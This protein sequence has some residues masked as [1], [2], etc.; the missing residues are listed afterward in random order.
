MA[1]P[2]LTAE[3]QEQVQ[4]AIVVDH[5]VQAARRSPLALWVLCFRAEKGEPLIIKD[6]HEAAEIAALEVLANPE[7]DG[8]LWEGARGLTKTSFLIALLLWVVGHDPESRHKWL[9]AGDDSA[10]KRMT[11]IRQVLRGPTDPDELDYYHMVFP[12]VK[13]D[14]NPQAKNTETQLTLERHTMTP[15]PTLEC[16]GVLTSGVGGRCDFMWL[17]DI[18]DKR[19]ALRLQALRPQVISGMVNDWLPTLTPSG[20]VFSV[21]NVWHRE[22]ACQYMKDNMKGWKV[23]RTFHGEPGDLYHSIFP[24]LQPSDW[25]KRKHRQEKDTAYLRGRCGLLD[26]SGT[27]IVPASDLESYTAAAPHGLTPARLK[28]CEAV[29]VVDPASGKKLEKDAKLD[30][31]GFAVLLWMLNWVPRD[32]ESGD[33]DDVM[34]GSP[35]YYVWIPEAFQVKLRA[36]AAIKLTTAMYREWG[37][38]WLVIEDQTGL[39]VM[40]WFDDQPIPADAIIPAMVK[41]M[42]KTDRLTDAS[43]MLQ[44]AAGEPRIVRF[45]PRTIERHP[46]PFALALPDGTYVEAERTLRT[47][48]L[49]HPTPH[50]DVMDPV[51]HGIRFI[52]YQ[53]QQQLPDAHTGDMPQPLTVS[54]IG[55]G[56]IR[57]GGGKSQ[58]TVSPV[59]TGLMA[60][61]ERYRAENPRP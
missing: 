11:T 14:M 53:V 33:P 49:N 25:L 55:G 21:F 44:S 30:Y 36:N 15:E 58:G 22:D 46:Q 50:D 61:I 43:R 24:E 39:S 56:S 12:D 16:R 51:V 40:P 28:Y 17:D 23:M 45:H 47:Q 59:S 10:K 42:S 48:I 27:V 57:S 26:T 37:A 52:D 60:A 41:S 7:D 38:D 20:K 3:Q 32:P 35:P 31:W 34:L 1:Q 18:V 5:W 4:L 54:R 13:I 19:N 29:L 6:F 8:F 2:E 9:G